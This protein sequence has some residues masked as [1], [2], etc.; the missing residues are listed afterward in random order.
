MK[1][2]SDMKLRD[3]QMKK[4]RIVWTASADGS[5]IFTDIVYA[6]DSKSAYNVYRHEHPLQ[7]VLSCTEEVQAMPKVDVYAIKV[8]HP[9][10]HNWVNN[11]TYPGHEDWLDFKDCS[12]ITTVP[13]VCQAPTYSHKTAMSIA[14]DMNTKYHGDPQL[15][16]EFD[17]TYEFTPVKLS[18]WQTIKDKL[19]MILKI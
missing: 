17:G 8:K 19:S 13:Y 1:C 14:K 4:F 12:R 3:G 7:T 10:R 18:K 15:T 11:C 9:S 5:M 2:E 16:L 6:F